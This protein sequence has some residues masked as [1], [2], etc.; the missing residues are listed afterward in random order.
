MDAAHICMCSSVIQWVIGYQDK[1]FG[2][3]ANI[4]NEGDAG[5]GDAG[6][7]GADINVGGR[8]DEDNGNGDDRGDDGDG[9]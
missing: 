8:V 7:G 9:L 1:C 4:N 5:E 2:A 6:E 3:W